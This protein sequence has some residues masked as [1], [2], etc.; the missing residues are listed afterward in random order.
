MKNAKL[1]KWANVFKNHAH[2]CNVEILNSFNPDLQPRITEFVI[3]NKLKNLLNELKGFKF[4]I[5]LSLNKK[6]QYTLFK[7]LGEMLPSAFLGR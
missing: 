5:I 7:C 1:T 4:V 3:K 6:K 2:T